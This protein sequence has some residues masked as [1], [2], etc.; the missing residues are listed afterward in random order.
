MSRTPTRDLVATGLFAALTGVGAF[1]RIPLEPVPF[2]LQPL[3]VLLAG[4]VL[5]PRLALASQGVYLAA[6]LLGLPVFVHGGGPAYVLQPTFGFLVGFALG[7]WTIS[8]VIH[9]GPGRGLLKTVTALIAGVAV[10]Y[11][12]GVAGL[13]LNLALFQGKPEVF[14]TVAWGLLAYLGLDLVKAAIAAATAGP[15]R[16]ALDLEVRA[17]DSDLSPPT[18]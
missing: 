5:R 12:C 6:G 2:T 15:V 17:G 3:V 16:R 8:W 10:I 11:A 4:A 9:T 18:R 1:L 14:G 13:F 7:A